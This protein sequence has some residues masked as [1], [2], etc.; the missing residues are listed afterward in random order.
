MKL[1]HFLLFFIPN[2][3]FVLFVQWLLQVT[4]LILFYL[5]LKV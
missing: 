1:D 4:D 5:V 3:Y 2:L